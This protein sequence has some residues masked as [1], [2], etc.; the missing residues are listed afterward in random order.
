MVI[1]GV[2]LVWCTL[3]ICV[4]CYCH[5]SWSTS[6]LHCSS[7]SVLSLSYTFPLKCLF[8]QS[9]CHLTLVLLKFCSFFW[10]KIKLLFRLVQIYISVLHPIYTRFV[11]NRF[12]IK[13]ITSFTFKTV[14]ALD[15]LEVKRS[16]VAVNWNDSGV[17]RF[18][19]SVLS[20]AKPV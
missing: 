4:G 13:Y 16:T 11:L 6:R 3:S 1:I 7:Q 14:G 8:S 17:S 5:F 2:Y 15:A 20:W 18:Q 19:T 10:K 9:S 12:W